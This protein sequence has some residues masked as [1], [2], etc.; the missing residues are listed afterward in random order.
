MESSQVEINHVP[1]LT[2][3]NQAYQDVNGSI[4][5]KHEPRYKNLTQRF[6]QLYGVQP[7]FFCR[8]PG[9]VNIIGEHI[10][11]CGYSVLPAA[12][13]QDFVMAY[14]L[15]EKEE[16]E[17]NNIDKDQY[18]KEKLS[19]DPFQKF[20]EGHHWINY[21]I[22]GY[23]AVLAIDDKYYSKILSP[24]GFKVLIDSHVPPAAGVSSS[25]AFTVCAA[26]LTASANNML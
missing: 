18:P 6:K 19:T 7:D 12:I 25:S 26:I 23:K 24:K 10:D 20:K 3:L 22:C 8:A 11:Y 16:I 5:Q 17:I 9:R 14:T 1:I 15:N 4:K 2:Q 21:F 13:E